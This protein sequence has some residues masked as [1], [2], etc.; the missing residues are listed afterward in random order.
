MKRLFIR[1]IYNPA[2]IVQLCK[3]YSLLMTVAGLR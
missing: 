1:H 3:E 2:I